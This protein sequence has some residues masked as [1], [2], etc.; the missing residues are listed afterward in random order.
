MHFKIYIETQA[1]PLFRVYSFLYDFQFFSSKEMVN[2]I[3]NKMCVL[4]GFSKAQ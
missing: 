1:V 4:Q 3:L 2:K